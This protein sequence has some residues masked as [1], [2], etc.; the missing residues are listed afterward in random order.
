MANLAF[1]NHLDPVLTETRDVRDG[2]EEAYVTRTGQLW[3]NAGTG[4]TAARQ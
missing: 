1:D 3:P 2:I 4:Q